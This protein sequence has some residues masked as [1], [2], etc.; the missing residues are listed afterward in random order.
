MIEVPRS[1]AKF[2]EPTE[3]VELHVFGDTSGSV[4]SAAAYAVIQQASEVSQRLIAAKSR[5][6]KKNLT[7]P[8]LEL[9]VAHMAANLVEN[10]RN[11]LSDQPIKS[12]YG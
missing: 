11:A 10:V 12:V 3:G 6:A 2:K 7:I 4:I 8:R 1:L 5:L 9:V